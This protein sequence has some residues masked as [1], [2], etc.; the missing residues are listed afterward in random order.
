MALEEGILETI[1]A[2]LGLDPAYTAFDEEVTVHIN[3][4]IFN[5]R[6]L[7][8]G[9]SQGFSVTAPTQ[10]WADYLGPEAERYGQTKT[11]IYLYLRGVFDP[12]QTSFGINAIKEQK[13]EAGWRLMIEADGVQNDSTSP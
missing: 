11:Y 6:Q 12:P 4:A 3:S 10:T 9:P 2:M 7:G 8:V 1:K 13:E 5:L